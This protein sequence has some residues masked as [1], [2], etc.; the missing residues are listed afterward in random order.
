MSEKRLTYDILMNNYYQ[1]IERGD[2]GYYRRLA[3]TGI[4]D[5]L[6]EQEQKIRQLEKSIERREEQ[7]S[8]I[9][10]HC[11]K[12]LTDEQFETIRKELENE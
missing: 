3:P 7:I 4:I 11:L 12:F 10:K 8:I 6:N 1:I 5:S 2:D 9:K